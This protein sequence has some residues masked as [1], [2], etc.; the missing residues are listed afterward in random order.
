MSPKGANMA[1]RILREGEVHIRSAVVGD[2]LDDRSTAEL[3]KELVS[4][5]Q[6]LVREEVRLAKLELRHELSQAKDVARDGAIAGVAGHT[7][8]LLAAATL[9][10]LLATVMPGWVAGLLITAAFGGVAAFFGLRAKKAAQTLKLKKPTE[11]LEE[12]ARWAKET[13]RGAVSRARANA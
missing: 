12:D 7:A 11:R 10:L 2:G 13:I 6:H 4:E 8:L 5:G 9:V 1:E 3:F